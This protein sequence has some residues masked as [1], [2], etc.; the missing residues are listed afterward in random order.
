MLCYL[1]HR[2]ENFKAGAIKNRLN[3]WESITSDPE[4]LSTVSGLQVQFEGDFLPFT[5]SSNTIITTFSD[6]EKAFIEVEV[7]KFLKKAVIE[8]SVHEENEFI[9]PIFLV[10]KDG[11]SY[12][13][14]LNLKKIKFSCAL[15]TF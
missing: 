7:S 13:L 3:I 5:E 9:S 12:R 14:I 8:H 2:V 4:T 1:Q 6:H 15:C 10:P 11:D